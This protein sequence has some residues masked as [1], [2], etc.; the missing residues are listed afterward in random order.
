MATKTES[1]P[2]PQP[3][4]MTAANVGGVTE[5]V[6]PPFASAVMHL[7]GLD[8]CDMEAALLVLQAEGKRALAKAHR[9]GNTEAPGA[10]ARAKSL[11]DVYKLLKR[12]GVEAV[13]RKLY[14]ETRACFA[15]RDIVH[16]ETK[17]LDEATQAEDIELGW[18]DAEE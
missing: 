16:P 12:G 5:A 3:Q 4:L 7:G 9:A 10:Q 17:P 8:W 13:T 11:E 15:L 18:D 6:K 1:K 2:T 14:G